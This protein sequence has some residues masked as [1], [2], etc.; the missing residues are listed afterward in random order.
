MKK[1]L[2]SIL[3]FVLL[4]GLLAGCS[5]ADKSDTLRTE[6]TTEQKTEKA[7]EIFLKSFNATTVEALTPLVEPGTSTELIEK[8]AADAKKTLENI[9]VTEI[10]SIDIEYIEA[11]EGYDIFYVRYENNDVPGV[12][13]VG[14]TIA[15][16]LRI[17][18]SYYVPNIADT[19]MQK[20]IFN[21]YPICPIALGR[22]PTCNGMGYIASDEATDASAETIVPFTPELGTYDTN[23]ALTYGEIAPETNTGSGY[24]ISDELIGNYKTEDDGSVSYYVDENG[25]G[26]I[27][28]YPPDYEDE[29]NKQPITV[30]PNFEEVKVPALDSDIYTDITL[31]PDL[32]VPDDALTVGPIEGTI[33]DSNFTICTDCNGS[34]SCQQP[35]NCEECNG[36]GYHINEN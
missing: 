23:S 16:L 15:P 6:W 18:E 24:I 19:P 35:Q 22:C 1:L 7:N 30:K 36:R 29:E 20:K 9:G 17:E 2:S 21:R 4:T 26:V 25:N 10:K 5:K 8:S 14:I 27:S 13:S 3:S 28:Y 31:N 12:E 11:F 34:G 33:I 32:I